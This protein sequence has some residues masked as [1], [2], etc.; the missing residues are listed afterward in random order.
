MKKFLIVLTV[1]AMASFLFVGCTPTAPAVDEEVVDEEA[2]PASTTPVIETIGG[3]VEVE[4]GINLY[5]SD[6]QY[7]NKDKAKSGILVEGYAPK[8]S[9][10]QV[11]IN[12]IVVGTST[13][14][15]GDE[16]FKVFISK[17]SL[18][19]DGVKTLYATT[20][21]VG[22]DESTPSTAYAFTLDTV[23]PKIV[24]VTAEVEGLTGGSEGTMT[25]T[26][27]EAIDEDT[28]YEDYTDIWDVARRDSTTGIFDSSLM[29]SVPEY[30]LISPEV[31]EL[32]GTFAVTF[33]EG[34]LIRVKYEPS[35]S[36]HAEET[37]DI[38]IRDLAGNK[39]LESVHYCY[40]E[41]EED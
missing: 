33:I 26:C 12:G 22:L 41:V 8:Y 4:G 32:S 29:A 11:Y 34:E 37:D 23:A 31:I 40:L 19:V 36:P 25:V 6:I 7:I 24:S 21:E 16:M 14:Y 9:T 20:I 39:L 38:Y 18:G 17:T 35:D 28:L 1:V 3:E 5:S 15:G 2:L 13:A 30:D 10:V 27:S